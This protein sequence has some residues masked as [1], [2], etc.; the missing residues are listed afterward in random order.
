MRAIALS[1][2]LAGLFAADPAQAPQVVQ[3]ATAYHD[4]GRAYV[5]AAVAAW[6]DAGM[7]PL[8]VPALPAD[9]KESDKEK[10]RL[11][12]VLNHTIET[13]NKN[14]RNFLQPAQ[15]DNPSA[16]VE[17]QALLDKVT[18]AMAKAEAAGI[19]MPKAKTKKP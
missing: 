18:K 16:P 7:E 1:L 15:L 8:P 6:Y 11:V 3:A 12:A 2:I 5:Q 10:A 13:A 19:T 9:P 4:A 17:L 14:L